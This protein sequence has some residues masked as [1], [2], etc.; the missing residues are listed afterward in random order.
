MK[1]LLILFAMAAM[2]M[3]APAQQFSGAVIVMRYE[4]PDGSIKTLPSPTLGKTLTMAECQRD[5][6]QQVRILKRQLA[7]TRNFPEFTGWKFISGQCEMY[8]DDLITTVK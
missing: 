5:A 8:S 6:R 3:P 1:A 4:A 7:N 2:A